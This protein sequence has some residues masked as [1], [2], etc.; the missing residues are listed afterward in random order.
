MCDAFSQA[1]INSHT[2]M[3]QHVWLSHRPKIKLSINSSTCGRR[4]YA[5][6]LN[7]SMEIL[8]V[9]LNLRTKWPII[10][11]SANLAAPRLTKNII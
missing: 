9:R 3:N 8:E 4:H 2:G 11:K 6:S 5:A 1:A 7:E 10:F